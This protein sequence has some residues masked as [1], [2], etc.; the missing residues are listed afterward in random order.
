MII[1]TKIF[2]KQ[3]NHLKQN[4][5]HFPKS[6]QTPP[7]LPPPLPPPS[8]NNSLHK[9]YPHIKIFPSHKNI[10]I[11][12]REIEIQFWEY[13]PGEGEG[14]GRGWKRDLCG[15][16]LDGGSWGWQYQNRWGYRQ[17]IDEVVVDTGNLEFATI[18]Y[19]ADARICAYILIQI[20]L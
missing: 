17:G 14:E 15:G 9:Y 13:G 4:P 7:P 2:P 5:S 18:S 3:T 10:Y 19:Y 8:S 11:Y 1:A 12:R 16:G 6:P 20:I